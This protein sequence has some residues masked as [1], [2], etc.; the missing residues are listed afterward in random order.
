M[1][2]DTDHDGKN[3]HQ[4]DEGEDDD[5]VTAIVVVQGAAPAEVEAIKVSKGG[6]RDGNEAGKKMGVVDLV[7]RGSGGGLS[8]DQLMSAVE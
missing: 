4:N 7:G 5:E 8:D 2:I 3:A 6:G 1:D